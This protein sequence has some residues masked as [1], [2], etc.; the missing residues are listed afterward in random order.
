MGVFSNV[1]REF[2]THAKVNLSGNI[3]WDEGHHLGFLL[4]SEYLGLVFE[5]H[6]IVSISEHVANAVFVNLYPLWNECKLSLD[7]VAL[8]LVLNFLK[9][10]FLRGD[11]ISVFLKFAIFRPLFLLNIELVNL[12][13]IFLS[14][15]SIKYRFWQRVRYYCF[16][17]KKWVAFYLLDSW[18]HFGGRLKDQREEL[19]SF[20]RDSRV[21]WYFVNTVLDQF[22]EMGETIGLASEWVLP[23]QQ[24]EE[25]NT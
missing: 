23:R 17:A 21:V 14:Q 5:F 13:F 1:F 24:S 16:L 15:R 8:H 2:L 20:I 9:N 7:L 4:V 3:P 6:A 10:L 12:K 18:P 22:F 25:N 11:Q 19:S